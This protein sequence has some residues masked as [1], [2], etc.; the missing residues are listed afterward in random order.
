MTTKQT[1]DRENIWSIQRMEW[2]VL[3]NKGRSVA[4]IRHTTG[5]NNV[6]LWWNRFY[7]L[8]KIIM[9]ATKYDYNAL[10]LEYFMSEKSEVNRFFLD[11]GLTFNSRVRELTKWRG[12]EKQKRLDD[13]TAKALERKKNEIAKKLEIPIDDLFKT[14]KQAIELMKVKLNQYVKKVNNAKDDEDVPINMKDLEKIRKVA[15]VELW[16]PTI[17]AKNEWS[18]NWNLNVSWWPLVQI[19][20]DTGDDENEEPEIDDE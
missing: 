12:K 4:T 14:K 7:C 1:T 5:W 9:Q 10:K 3:W 15:K 8:L 20:R 16:E 11:K 18:V 19:V 13:I 6:C 17:V 2:F